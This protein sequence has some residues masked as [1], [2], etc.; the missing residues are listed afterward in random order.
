MK[1]KILRPDIEKR[2]KYLM[3]ELFHL[4]REN[5]LA[6]CHLKATNCETGCELHLTVELEERTAMKGVQG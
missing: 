2:R 6:H 1:E 5:G 3:D 4:M